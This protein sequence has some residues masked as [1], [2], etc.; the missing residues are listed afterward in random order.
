M[1]GI[2]QQCVYSYLALDKYTQTSNDK[3]SSVTNA[4]LSL[5][6]V[7]VLLLLLMFSLLLLMLFL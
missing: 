3:Q 6:L 7:L 5:F 1:N 2:L 4:V